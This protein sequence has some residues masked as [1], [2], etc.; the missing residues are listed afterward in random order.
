MKRDINETIRR[1][2]ELEKE[3]I[4]QRA[5]V[6]LSKLA[7]SIVY[8]RTKSGKGTNG[9][10]LQKLKPLSESYKLQRK[11]KLKFRTIRSRK[12]PFYGQDDRPRTIGKFFKPTKSNL[13]YTGQ[14]LESM[15]I[16]VGNFTFG[17]TIPNTRRQRQKGQ[18]RI[19]T[20]AE[21]AGYVEANGREFFALSKGE[22]RI[23]IKEYERLIRYAIRKKGL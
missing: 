4:N 2:E 3:L 6:R 11:G 21:V 12:V 5:F 8:K 18:K 19:L 13:T 20:N 16:E 9:T 15:I 1:I 14:M 10:G 22:V 23:I 7:R 17:V